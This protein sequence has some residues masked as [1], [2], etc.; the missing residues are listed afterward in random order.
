[1][2]DPDVGA[3]PVEHLQ[4]EHEVLPLVRVRYEE[5]LR[6]AVV[7]P[8]EVELLHV[9]VRVADADEG[10]ELRT[11]L[12][13]SCPLHL[14]P[15]PPPSVAVEIDAGG[16]TEEALLVAVGLLGHLGVEHHNDHVAAV[17]EVF[18]HG[19]LA[20]TLVLARTEKARS[21]MKVQHINAQ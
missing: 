8:I 19:L 15:L 7:L 14:L 11:L 5:R 2:E 18:P 4:R 6:G 12:R 20:Q 3:V 1:M 16:R 17:A 21:G 10:A 9:L 13:F